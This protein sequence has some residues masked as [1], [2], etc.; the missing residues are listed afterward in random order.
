MQER[1]RRGVEMEILDGDLDVIE[2]KMLVGMNAVV[3]L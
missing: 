2:Y 3:M 1:F